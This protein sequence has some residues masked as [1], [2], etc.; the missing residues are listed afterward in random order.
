MSNSIVQIARGYI[1]QTEK[2][3]NAGFLHADF[4][5]KMRDVAGFR[6]GEAWC[7]Y[8]AEL[9]LKEA[10]PDKVKFID[11]WISASTITTY[12]SAKAQCLNVS[13]TPTVGALVIFQSMKDGVGTAHGHAGIVTEVITPLSFKSVEGNTNNNGSAEGIMVLEKVRNIKPVS[14]GLQVKGFIVF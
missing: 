4:E 7:A 14:N 3:G 11:R 1:G 6:T 12:N 13:M 9:C 2:P 5:K 8:F 10:N